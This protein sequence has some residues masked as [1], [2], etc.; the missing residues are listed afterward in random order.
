MALFGGG[1]GGDNDDLFD[2][3]G[4]FDLEIPDVDVN[5]DETLEAKKARLKAELAAIEDEEK[6]TA[7]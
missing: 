5:G 2:F 3:S 6:G 4:M 7:K 1:L